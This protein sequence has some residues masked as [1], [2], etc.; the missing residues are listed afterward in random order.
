MMAKPKISSEEYYWLTAARS[1]G[2]GR[3]IRPKS[4]RR[5]FGRRIRR[6]RAGF[7]RRRK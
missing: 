1:Y 6:A 7:G 5:Y 2:G 3:P 4:V